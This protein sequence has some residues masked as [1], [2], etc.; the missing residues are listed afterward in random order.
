M[1]GYLLAYDIG[2]PRR[3]RSV[4]KLARAYGKALQYSVFICTLRRDQRVRLAQRLE[5]ILDRKADRAIIID[6][7]H[8]ADRGS[9]IPPVEVFGRQAIAPDDSVV[10]V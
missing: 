8:V 10:I 5:A 9:W 4:L 7:G 1:R 3:L 2:D 6:L